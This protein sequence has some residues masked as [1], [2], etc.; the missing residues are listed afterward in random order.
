MPLWKRFHPNFPSCFRYILTAAHCICNSN[1]D[2]CYKADENGAKS[3]ENNSLDIIAL[4]GLIFAANLEILNK[5]QQT[6]HMR[7]ISQAVIHKDYQRGTESTNFLP[8][9][10]DIA[11]LKMNEPVPND[12]K[13]SPIC[14]PAGNMFPDSGGSAH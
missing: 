14:L 10:P 6:K 9:G 1:V 4:L 7:F 5:N 11:L 8:K 13:S 2:Y 12:F 3:G